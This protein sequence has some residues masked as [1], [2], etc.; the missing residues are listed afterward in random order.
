M[1]L[2]LGIVFVMFLLAVAG[3]QS[4]GSD[5]NDPNLPPERRAASIVSRMTLEEK[6]SQMQNVAPAI[7]RL[8]VPAYD[9]WNEALHGVARAGLATVFPQAIGLAATW[10]TGLQ[11]RIASIIST[12]ARAKY[13]DAISHGNHGRYYGLT[14]WSPNINIFRDPRWGRGQE[15]YGE[16]PHLTAQ[17]AIQFIRGMQGDNPQYFKTIATSKHFAVHSG[18]ERLRHAFNVQ[19]SERD[20]QE[21]YLYAFRETVESADVASLMCA[22]NAVDG[23]PACASSSLLK[24]NLRES[25][26]FKG[27]VVSDCGAIDDIYGGH[28]FAD[29]PAKASALAVKAGTDLECGKAYR[30]LVEAVQKGYISEG[31]IDR[32]VE[33]LFAVRFRLGMFDPPDRVPFSKIGTDQV[34][35]EAHRKVALE[36]AEKS[37]VLLKNEDHLLPLEHAPKNIA[38]I[39]PT[40]DDPDA[41]LGN[42]NGIPC[43]II[44]PLEGVQREFG[45]RS[46]VE[47]AL[48]STYVAGWTA[49]IPQNALTP[50][51][52]ENKH[53]LLVEYFANEDLGG[54][55]QL[56]RVEPRGYFNWE[57]QDSAVLRAV[58]RDHF[59]VRWS[60]YLRVPQS[61]EYRL[62][63][64]RPEC[65]SCGRIDSARLYINGH[66]LMTD[67]Q[68]PDEQMFP[69]TA[70]VQLEAAK[71]Y[72]LRLDYSQKGG[73]GGLQL[74]WSPP[75]EAALKG[76]VELV[77]N[78]DLAILFLGLNSR[79][80][81]EESKLV[82]SGFVGGDRT[83][84]QLPEPQRN[85][86]EAVLNTGKPVVLVLV[87]GSALAINL[88][89]QKAKAILET[90]YG[91]QEAG[92][93]IANTLSGRNNP[94]GRLPVTF[95]QSVDQL[96]P[97]TD[98]S[99]SNRT[100]RYFKGQPL[101]PFGF[102]LSYSTFTYSNV[103]L[104]RSGNDTYRVSASVTNTS[105]REG[106]EVAQLYLSNQDGSNPRLIGFKRFRLTA[107]EART[108]SFE[109]KTS[110]LQGRVVTVSGGEPKTGGVTFAQSGV[111]QPTSQ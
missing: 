77:K 102:G 101:Y 100:Y 96:P 34:A 46:A 36:A 85:L 98:Y 87:N 104:E 80:E 27:Y 17:M 48:G 43:G 94:A 81:G 19:P 37:I 60:G 88:A 83:D 58:P 23:A 22:Y 32:S 107:G 3:A 110:E 44:T 20:L 14:F 97:F 33:R 68:R 66:L 62:G 92:T 73:G 55:P 89:K 103:K 86:L 91:G 82:I 99:M 42:Y 15:T 59:S 26:K 90:W 47:F 61:G 8:G 1:S 95:Y 63:V 74:V 29:S 76:A 21:T 93:A 79:L 5:Y 49:L 12:E 40:A 41:L 105:S 106:D 35:S 111:T 108:A 11:F 24:N 51:I 9:W 45:D 71:P 39:G 18:P 64:I 2:R 54:P 75:A 10:D 72:T 53:G 31:E 38:V 52:N 7:S 65:H 57:M 6:V 84:I 69:K 25:W 50:E 30:A 109:V 78:S 56:S 28:R 70:A 67:S 4:D 16:D 13:N